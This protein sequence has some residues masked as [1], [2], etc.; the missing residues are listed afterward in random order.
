LKRSTVLL[1]TLLVLAALALHLSV[2]WQ[3]FSTLAKNG[4]LYDDSFY[5]FQI[6]HN[7]A[8]GHGPTFDGVTLT[9]GFQPL[10]VF[11]LVP[12][13]KVLGPDRVLPIYYA[14]TLLALMTVA[15]A[16]LLF[17]IVRRYTSDGVALF[18]TMV[19]AFSPVVV[20]QSANGLETAMAL[21]LFAAS[22]Y[23]YLDR[24]RSNP[25]VRLSQFA[26]LG[27]LLGLAVLARVDQVLLILAMALDYLL[28][29]RRR[30]R[31][32][33][34]RGAL[35]GLGVSAAT[36][37]AVCLPWF[38]YGLVTVGSPLQESGAATRFL[39]I[40]YAP[41]FDLGPADTVERGVSVSF[42][43][44]HVVHAL[45]ILKVS[46]PVHAFYRGLERMGDGSPLSG[47]VLYA[48]NAVS[49]GALALFALW[50]GRGG[51]THATHNRR[52]LSFLILYAVLLAAAY[53]T[54]IFGV[55]FFTRYFYPVFFVASIFAAC[56]LQ[57]VMAWS[58]ARRPVIRFAAGGVFMLYA[59][60]LVYMGMTSAFRSSNVY[61]F[62]DIARWVEMNTSEDETIGVFQGGAIGYFSNR[63]VINLDGKVNCH[64]LDALRQ[65]E[66][67]EYIAEAG[68][69]VLMDH[70]N[71]LD[72][73]LGPDGGSEIAGVKTTRCFTGKSVGAPGWVGFRLNGR[74][75]ARGDA[76]VDAGSSG[77]A[78]LSN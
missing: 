54:W 48:V 57:D 4:Y 44:A 35:R 42:V 37:L 52:E 17:L 49:L 43:W 41:F 65:G 20:R 39:S 18:A 71:V 31:S 10:Y 70:C 8:A 11:M 24:V 59:L 56:V 47:W 73:F 67:N 29:V 77:A 14:L 53:S 61:R 74:D 40:A 26:K 78:S 64:A 25:L 63:R 75:R 51:R 55:F 69:D 7:I 21:F 5:A 36:V 46:P 1:A 33:E 19:W 58:L 27:L 60:V 45:S 15:T 16:L 34:S 22:V 66:I 76:R 23:Y 30:V 6:A 28:L 38:V 62:Y 2:S 12:A 32:G 3:D 13:Y 72:L 68:I 50:V 9:N